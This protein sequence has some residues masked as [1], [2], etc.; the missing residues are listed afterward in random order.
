MG[1]RRRAWMQ[2]ELIL[3]LYLYLREGPNPTSTSTADLSETLRA[4][5]VE[6]ELAADPRFRNP[7]AV[8][9]KVSNFAA[10][11]PSST[12]GGMSH[13][14]RGDR[15]VWTKFK[16]S[17]HRLREAAEAIRANLG[18]VPSSAFGDEPEVTD[19]EEG[20]ILTRVHRHRERDP[21]LRAAKCSQVLTAT[22]SLKCE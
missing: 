15:D 6:P 8:S 21:R 1:S 4:F 22:G 20:R 12:T 9:L 18:S 3:A 16:D 14:G 17:P 10:I 19:A 13:G 5:P 7:K 2:D 11:D